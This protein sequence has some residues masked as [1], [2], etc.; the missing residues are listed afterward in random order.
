[1]DFGPKQRASIPNLINNGFGSVG[2]IIGFT[3]P[4]W[5]EELA[6]K[7]LGLRRCTVKS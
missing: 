4:G 6:V 3:L 7:I 2:Q 1:M 5:E